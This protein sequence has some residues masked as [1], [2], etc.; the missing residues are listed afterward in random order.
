M[1]KL[2]YKVDKTLKNKKPGIYPAVIQYCKF[3]KGKLYIMLTAS[4]GLT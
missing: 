3:T 4:A 2:K 1:C